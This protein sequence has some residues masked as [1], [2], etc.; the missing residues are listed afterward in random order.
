MSDE[1]QEAVYLP[2]ILSQ[3]FTRPGRVTV[4]INGHSYALLVAIGSSL[5][6]LLNQ[7]TMSVQGD[8]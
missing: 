1:V 6:A 5:S 2:D 4:W 8:Y 3:W 7:F